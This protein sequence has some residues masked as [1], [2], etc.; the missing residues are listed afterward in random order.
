MCF[1]VPMEG[2]QSVRSQS[3]V[4]VCALTVQ[5]Q[6]LALHKPIKRDKVTE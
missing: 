5:A 2:D 1:S 6:S 4:I 3:E